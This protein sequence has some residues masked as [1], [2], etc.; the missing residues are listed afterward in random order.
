MNNAVWYNRDP[1]V[2]RWERR[3]TSPVTATVFWTPNFSF[4][5]YFDTEGQAAAAAS[6]F[7][8]VH[9]AG[10]VT[11]SVYVVVDRASVITGLTDREPDEFAWVPIDSE[12]QIDA[13]NLDLADAAKKKAFR[14]ATGAAAVFVGTTLPAGTATNNGDWVI[15]TTDVASGLVWQDFAGNT[16]TSADAG[17]LGV[18]VGGRTWQRLGN[19]I[20]GPAKIRTQALTS[21]A[22]ITWN[23]ASGHTATLTLGVNATLRISGGADG[24]LAFLKVKQD[25]TGSRTLALH[26]SILRFKDIAAPT[27]ST[28]ANSVD[29]LMFVNDGGTWNYVGHR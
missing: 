24:D 7:E 16:L 8:D 19:M 9:G 1:A 13:D 15:I 17:D 11:G 4:L 14:A 23:V 21:A 27:L 25:G 12:Y 20:Q 6:A 2:R 3:I 10:S 18:Y 26:A 5:G 22:A 29:L 28:T